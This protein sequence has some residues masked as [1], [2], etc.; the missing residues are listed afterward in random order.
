MQK[1]LP[2]I[3]Y[4]KSVIVIYIYIVLDNFVTFILKRIQ[5]IFNVLLIS[6]IINVI[7]YNIY[8]LICFRKKIEN[9]FYNNTQP[10]LKSCH[11][12]NIQEI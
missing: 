5:N 11:A 1:L 12:Y 8:G 4:L 7:K 6:L 9:H 2:N 3:N 10:T